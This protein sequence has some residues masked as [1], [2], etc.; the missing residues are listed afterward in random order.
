MDFAFIQLGLGRWLHVMAGVMWLGL[1]YYFSFVQA[2]AL[3]AGGR[4]SDAALVLEQALRVDPEFA[5]AQARL[6]DNLISLH[7]DTEGYEAWQRAMV[8]AERAQPTSREALQLVL[9]E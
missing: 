6:G 4:L 3:S 5:M 2:D 9:R 1:L 7:R 8:L